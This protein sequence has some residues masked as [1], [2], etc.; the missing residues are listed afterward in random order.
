SSRFCRGNRG[1]LLIMRP[2]RLHHVP[3]IGVDRV[4]READAALDPSILRME[5]LDTDLRP[6]VAAIEATRR[7][8]DDDAAN[9]YLPFFGDR[10]LCRAA[11]AHVSR[12]SRVHY[13][14]AVISAGACHGVFNTLLA[15]I[16]PGDE[17]ITT[18]PIYVGLLNRIRLA[19]GVPRF[20]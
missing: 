7:A 2:S 1:R 17:V 14:D 9:S 20:A 6:P 5:N 4:G 13:D 8:I 16:E 15:T 11:A 10:E 3:P 12:L 18:D 19:G